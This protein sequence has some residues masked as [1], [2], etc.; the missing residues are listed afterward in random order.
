MRFGK[1][2]GLG[3]APYFMQCA[4]GAA[5]VSAIAIL[6]GCTPVPPPDVLAQ[7]DRVR[8]TAFVVE[9]K[10]LAP[11]GFAHAEKLRAEANE[12]FAAGDRAGAQILGERAM[13]AYAHATMLARVAR[14]ESALGQSKDEQS[15]AKEELGAIDAEQLRV[16]A[17]AEALELRV[18]VVTDAQPTLASE[19]SDGDREKARLSASRSLAVQGRLL[20]G[21]AQLL[22]AQMP[23]DEK[24]KAPAAPPKTPAPGSSEDA[25]ASAGEAL[26][27]PSKETLSNKLLDLNNALGKLETDLAAGPPVPIDQASRLRAGCLSVLTSIRRTKTPVSSAPGAGDTLLSELSAV[28]NWAPSR[29]DRGVFVTLRGLFKGDA[30]LPAGSAR[31]A[32]LGRIAAA[33]PSFPVL[34]VVHQDKE[35]GKKDEGAWKTRATLVAQAIQSASASTKIETFFPG[36]AMPAVDPEGAD[37][38]RNARVEI[39]FVTPETF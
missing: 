23:A 12:A 13:A 15:K 5:M 33:H 19:K 21:A 30:L 35:P 16:T 22:L 38:A 7:I 32:E 27:P 37:R 28:G 24:P 3:P 14:A 26:A 31:L 17:E 18:K 6:Q 2:P 36:T 34:V 39:I 9:A 4:R 8:G 11:A 1:M 25:L 29:D 10:E 20:C